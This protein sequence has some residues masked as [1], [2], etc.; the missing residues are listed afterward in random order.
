MASSDLTWVLA[1]ACGAIIFVAIVVAIVKLFTY[2]TPRARA[3]R[4][5]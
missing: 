1:G 4:R 2:E 3:A 5:H